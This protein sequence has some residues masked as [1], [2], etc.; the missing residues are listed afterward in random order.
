MLLQGILLIVLILESYIN[1]D[2]KNNNQRDKLKTLNRI[3]KA[4]NGAIIAVFIF[5]FTLFIF[6]FVCH[7]LATFIATLSHNTKM[8]F[9]NT[10][11]AAC[12]FVWNI[13][14]EPVRHIPF[15][16]LFNDNERLREGRL[17]FPSGCSHASCCSTTFSCF[18]N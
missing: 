15:F 18:F 14:S 3:K 2:P 7:V 13:S 17:C 11:A 4:K 5:N 10:H 12:L 16:P 9:I 1:L 6:S 8:W